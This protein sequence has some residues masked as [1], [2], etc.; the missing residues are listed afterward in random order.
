MDAHAQKEGQD[1]ISI[2][3]AP[4]LSDEEIHKRTGWWIQAI[5]PFSC[6][7]KKFPCKVYSDFKSNK[8]KHNC[9]SSDCYNIS[10]YLVRCYK[11]DTEIGHDPMKWGCLEQK[12]ICIECGQLGQLSNYQ[13]QVYDKGSV[14]YYG[15]CRVCSW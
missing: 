7:C 13:E 5:C 8:S 9:M 11:R 15:Q 10:C 3:I 14:T 4:G 12:W 2:G 1:E 6:Y